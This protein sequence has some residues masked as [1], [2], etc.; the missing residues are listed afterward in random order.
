MKVCEYCGTKHESYQAC[1]FPDSSSRKSRFSEIKTTE[2][3]V[4]V[5]GS[6]EPY[7]K[8]PTE[9]GWVRCSCG[10]GERVKARPV[11]YSPA[12]RVRAKRARDKEG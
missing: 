10:C 11:Y 9:L 5:G 8:T 12:C 2:P 6:A 7:L 3:E 1:V 4:V